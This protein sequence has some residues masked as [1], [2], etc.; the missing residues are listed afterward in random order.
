MSGLART[1]PSPLG[2]RVGVRGLPHVGV[3]FGRFGSP[4]SSFDLA[5]RCQVCVSFSL[6]GEGGFTLAGFLQSITVAE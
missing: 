1:A 5:T 6:K 4:S 2:E 3:S